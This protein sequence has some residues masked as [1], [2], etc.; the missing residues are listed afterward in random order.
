MPFC[1][2]CGATV[3]GKFCPKCGAAVGAGSVPPPPPPG[4]TFDASGI[5]SNVASLLCYIIPV[6][7]PI[8]FLVVDPYKGNRKIRFDAFQSLFLSVGFV[9][10]GICV[11]I[12][13]AMSGSLGAAIS[14]LVNLA[15]LVIIVYLA[16]KA[17]QNQKVVLP[18]IGDLAE[19]Q[20]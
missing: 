18:V 20:A 14:P 17:F 7:C 6:V 10:I 8:I 13:R 9:V 19:K 12:L 3:D 11:E 15:E 4:Q 2:S 5:P 1:A 16:F